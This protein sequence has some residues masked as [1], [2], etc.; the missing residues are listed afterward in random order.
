M[1]AVQCPSCGR[2]SPVFLGRPDWIRCPAC[3]Y[4]GAPPPECVPSLQR[5][6]QIV[7]GSNQRHR[8]LGAAQRRT[9]LLGRGGSH[10]FLLFA[11]LAATPMFACGACGVVLSA[12]SEHFIFSDVALMFT[13]IASFLLPATALWLW[14]ARTRRVLEEACVAV[15]PLV[16]G[17]P[18]SCYVCGGPLS[19]SG[20]QPLARC[21]WCAADNLVDPKAL[22]RA[23]HRQTA[24][25][26]SLESEVERQGRIAAS[27]AQ[28]ASALLIPAAV[29]VPVVG[30]VVAFVTLAMID[31][32]P[33]LDHEYVDVATPKGLCVAQVRRSSGAPPALHFDHS[34]PEGVEDEYGPLLAGQVPYRARDVPG[35]R[36][37]SKYGTGAGVALSLH[38]TQLNHRSNTMK[39]RTDDGRTTSQFVVGSCR[40]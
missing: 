32:P 17:E 14:L 22:G 1:L 2:P 36:F 13:P 27:T 37:R 5:A 9:L 23:A 11:F 25:V 33:H 4:Q 30:L 34:P 26:G 20:V 3:H 6:A 16:A 39:L 31:L 35:R 12:T 19:S 40:P 15:P 7:I 24:A 38:S 18:A 21:P 29:V 28:T 8:Q 10:R